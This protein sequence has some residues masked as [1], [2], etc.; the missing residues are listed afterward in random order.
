M[1]TGAGPG[2][3][4]SV[5]NH[6]EKNENSPAETV[7]SRFGELAVCGVASYLVEHFVLRLVIDSQTVLVSTRSSSRR[8]HELFEVAK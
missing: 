1:L 3:V 5:P 2:R 4:E 6:S 8:S 7:E